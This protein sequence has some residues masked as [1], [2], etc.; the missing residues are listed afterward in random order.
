MYATHILFIIYLF[1]VFTSS[2]N[3]REAYIILLI[4]FCFCFLL[5]LKRSI[6]VID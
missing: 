1:G 5:T 2:L 6:L 4:V 3:S